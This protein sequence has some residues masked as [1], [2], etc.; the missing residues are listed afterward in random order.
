[1]LKHSPLP[2]IPGWAVGEEAWI[3]TCGHVGCENTL[4][5]K[6]EQIVSIFESDWTVG[7]MRIGCPEHP[8]RQA[9]IKRVV[10]RCGGDPDCTHTITVGVNE[11]QDV[12]T[13]LSLTKHEKVGSQ[14]RFCGQ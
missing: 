7:L 3:F 13:I 4:R 10:L 6:A 14:R 9:D 11:L 12:S 8:T 1:M 5:I 2:P